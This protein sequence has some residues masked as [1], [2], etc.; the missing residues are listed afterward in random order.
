M[1]RRFNEHHFHTIKNFLA[2]NYSD[3][4]QPHNFERAAQ[5]VKT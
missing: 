1:I 2:E 5:K 3:L 4:R